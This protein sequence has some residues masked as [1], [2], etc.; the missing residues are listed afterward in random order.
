MTVRE[1]I[2][3]ELT[4]KPITKIVRELGQGVINI[5]E[6]EV[7]KQVAKIKAT[8][9]MVEQGCKYSFLILFLGKAQY[10]IVIG[11][12]KIQW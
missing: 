1:H 4:T 12:K 8:E 9:H 2:L 10:G 3:A 11:N 6:A 5:L 7:T